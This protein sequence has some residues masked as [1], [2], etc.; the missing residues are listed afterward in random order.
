MF[1]LDSTTFQVM[2]FVFEIDTTCKT[3]H[4]LSGESETGCRS[5][6]K[7]SFI[8]KQGT[9]YLPQDLLMNEPLSFPPQSGLV[10]VDVCVEGITGFEFLDRVSGFH[11]C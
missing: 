8:R 3:S 10:C 9:T 6:Y 1:F 11:I 4:V 7:P 2:V 5:L